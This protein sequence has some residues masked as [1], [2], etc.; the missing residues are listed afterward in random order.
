MSENISSVSARVPITYFGFGYE[1]LSLS[2][3]LS[4]PRFKAFLNFAKVVNVTSSG[5]T[6]VERVY[7]RRISRIV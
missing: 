3:S 5:I 7:V 1:S 6:N 2:L 4:L